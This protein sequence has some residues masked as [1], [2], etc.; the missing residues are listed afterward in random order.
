MVHSRKYGVG[1][2]T[3][4]S[5]GVA[6]FP[7]TTWAGYGGTHQEMEAGEST[8]SGQLLVAWF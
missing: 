6:L 2:G 1:G 5:E 7:N 3:D 4:L 8:G